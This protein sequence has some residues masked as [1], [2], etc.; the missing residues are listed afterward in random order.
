MSAECYDRNMDGLQAYGILLGPQ[1]Y[2]EYEI[3]GPDRSADL[4]FGDFFDSYWDGIREGGNGGL[5]GLERYAYNCS[6]MMD[7]DTPG[8]VLQR[9]FLFSIQTVAFMTICVIFICSTVS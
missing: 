4:C 9:S 5:E 3:M 1:E 2:T 8:T 7:L 6:L